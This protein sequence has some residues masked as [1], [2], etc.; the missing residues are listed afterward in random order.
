MI[1]LHWWEEQVHHLLGMTHIVGPWR[2]FCLTSGHDCWSVSLIPALVISN[3]STN[4]AKLLV[5]R[6]SIYQ[7]ESYALRL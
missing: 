3:N 7:H 6:S 5:C 1:S 2:F 4:E